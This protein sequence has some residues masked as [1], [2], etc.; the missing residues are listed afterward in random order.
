MS[1]VIWINKTFWQ[2]KKLKKL[3][4]HLKQRAHNNTS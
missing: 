1:S 3:L 4:K 2:I